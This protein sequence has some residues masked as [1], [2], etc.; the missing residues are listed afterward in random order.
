LAMGRPRTHAGLGYG[1]A[2]RGVLCP[3]HPPALRPICATVPCGAAL[4]ATRRG[5]G[6]A[7]IGV[8]VCQ[9]HLL[10]RG[11]PLSGH[12]TD[13]GSVGPPVYGSAHPEC[14]ALSLGP[15]L[16][17]YLS[18]APALY[19]PSRAECPLAAACTSARTPPPGAA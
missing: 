18:C 5:D 3:V 13:P 19:D 7:A 10:D 9:W 6:T 14:R 15:C 4:A 12:A 2:Y 16:G 11:V 8:G 17:P 1:G